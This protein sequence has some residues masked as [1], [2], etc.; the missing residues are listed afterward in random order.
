[1]PCHSGRGKRFTSSCF[2]TCVIT[3]TASITK[4]SQTTATCSTCQ[5]QLHTKDY[6]IFSRSTAFLFFFFFFFFLPSPGDAQGQQQRSELPSF[7]QGPDKLEYSLGLAA[8][9]GLSSKVKEN[10][11]NYFFSCVTPG[12]ILLF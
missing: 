8:L 11:C 3:P 2:V 7:M 5:N 9:R 4:C 1:M 12:K 10:L 6:T